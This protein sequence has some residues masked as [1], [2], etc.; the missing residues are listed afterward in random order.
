[1]SINTLKKNALLFL[2][3]S[4]FF[5]IFFIQAPVMALTPDISLIQSES[6][7]TARYT[8][9]DARRQHILVGDARGGGHKFGMGRAEKSEFPKEWDDDKIINIALMIANDNRWPQR[10][11]GRYWLKLGEVEGLH[12]RVVLNREKMEIVT[13]YPI[14]VRRN[15]H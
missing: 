3:P 12:I 11:S 2:L 13:A 15:L 5:I 10:P 1:M 7:K 9:T 6:G 14:N 8:I 4:F